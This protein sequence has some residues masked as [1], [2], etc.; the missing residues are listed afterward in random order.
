MTPLDLVIAVEG[1]RA[2]AWSVA[3]VHDGPP[4]AKARA[5]VT[6]FRGRPR[7]YTPDA[8]AAA[9][10][11]LGWRWR[12]ALRGATYDGALA[13]GMLFYRPDRRR[14]DVDNLVKLVLDAGTKARAW[15]DDSQITTVVA[16]LELDAARPRTE[17]ALVPSTS[18]LV[19]QLADT[20][21]AATAARRT[22]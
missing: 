22:R 18:T 17:V 3:F 4:I 21:T 13:I 8:T 16:R 2:P 9:E 5:R 12:I 15:H 1:S 14:I 11:A 19:R 7:A 20:S 6:L 10:A